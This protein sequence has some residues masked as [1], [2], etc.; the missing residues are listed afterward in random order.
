M[1]LLYVVYYAVCYN[2]TFDVIFTRNNDEYALILTKNT[3][4]IL[5]E[6]YLNTNKSSPPSWL[7]SL[8][9]CVIDSSIILQCTSNNFLLLFNVEFKF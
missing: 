2:A 1:Q 3:N 8:I 7:Y 6:S 9:L 4:T 5:L